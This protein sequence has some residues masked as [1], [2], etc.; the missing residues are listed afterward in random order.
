MGEVFTVLILWASLFA[1]STE[2]FP[3]PRLVQEAGALH[4]DWKRRFVEKAGEC[5]L[6]YPDRE[7][8]AWDDFG[9]VYVV[10]WR[11]A[12]GRPLP[13]DKRFGEW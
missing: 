1:P 13:N 3:P 11:R 6:A 8:Y 7:R 2:E 5:L 12:Q 9:G 10:L 4:H